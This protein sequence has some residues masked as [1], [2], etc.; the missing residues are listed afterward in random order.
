MS[1]YFFMWYNFPIERIIM[2]SMFP[3]YSKLI[4]N[5][6]KDRGFG[7]QRLTSSSFVCGGI[8][9]FKTTG[10]TS[11]ARQICRNKAQTHSYVNSAGILTPSYYV[12]KRGERIER[13][14]PFPLVLKPVNGSLGRDVYLRINKEIDFTTIA[15]RIIDKRGE[16]LVE[17]YIEG[18]KYR[19]FASDKK[20][21][22]VIEYEA[23]IIIG[24]GR[25]ALYTLMKKEN[26]KKKAKNKEFPLA[27][28]PMLRPADEVLKRAKLTYASIL[29]KGRVLNLDPM[30]TRA[31]GSHSKEILD[32]IENGSFDFCYKAVASIPELKTTGVD[33]IIEKG[34]GRKVFL[35]VNGIPHLRANLWPLEGNP[36][37]VI[38]ELVGAYL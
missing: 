31:T 6:C 24:D 19:V 3:V 20:L 5:E 8:E 10:S 29:P 9:F 18:T 12:I 16:V 21:I 30:I 28:F 32:T 1:A 34:T 26:E 36:Q 14:L 38:K 23:P 2:A 35:E 4:E 13:K 17:E 37:P 22:S 11:S 33:V 15:K 7:V 25:S 27:N